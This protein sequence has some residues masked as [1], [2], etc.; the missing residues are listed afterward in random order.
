L[1]NLLHRTAR[2]I[3]GLSE[4][5]GRWVG[6]AALGAV[7][8]TFLVV[9]LRYGFDWGSI[10]MQESVLYLHALIF[11]AGAGYTL[12]HDEHV[13]VDI[14]YRGMS[15]RRRAWVDLLGSLLLLL[16]VCGF[17]VWTSADYVWDAWMRLEGSRQTGGLPLIYLLKSYILLFAVL[18]GLQGI[19]Q[20]IRAYTELR[21]ETVP[22]EPPAREGP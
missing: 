6:W 13:R 19:A 8:V 12:K 18:L 20:A 2:A 4:H 16:P 14:F 3:E 5:T 7:L 11:M 10:A 1:Y 15:P 21:G 17:I 22:H 9:V